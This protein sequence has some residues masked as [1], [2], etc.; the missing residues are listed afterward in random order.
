MKI[1]RM[2]LK[3]RRPAQRPDPPSRE[4]E[5]DDE[6]DGDAAEGGKLVERRDLGHKGQ[7]VLRSREAYHLDPRLKGRR[8]DKGRGRA[9]QRFLYHGR[10]HEAAVDVQPPV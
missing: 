10:L 1:S 9:R 2:F 3:R 4:G 8:C 6:P 5:R 7:P